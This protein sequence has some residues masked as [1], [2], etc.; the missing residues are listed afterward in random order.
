MVEILLYGY[1]IDK[2]FKIYNLKMYVILSKMYDIS[3]D[4]IK[5]LSRILRDSATPYEKKQNT[6]SRLSGEQPD[7]WCK[8]TAVRRNT[9]RGSGCHTHVARQRNDMRNS[10]RHCFQTTPF[11]TGAMIV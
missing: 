7:D 9:R 4:H 11:P 5:K 3:S 1:N 2:F 6:A 10:Q 8:K